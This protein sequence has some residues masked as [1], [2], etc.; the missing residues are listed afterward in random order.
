MPLSTTMDEYCKPNTV[1]NASEKWLKKSKATCLTLIL[2]MKFNAQG[3]QVLWTG[4]TASCQNCCW[5]GQRDKRLVSTICPR[6]WHRSDLIKQGFPQ[7]HL[8]LC[9]KPLF[10]TSPHSLFK[11]TEDEYIPDAESVRQV[12]EQHQQP[13]T[14]SLAQ[15]FQLYTK[16]EQVNSSHA[17][18]N[19]RLFMC[20]LLCAN[21]KCQSLPSL[22]PACSGW[23]L[24]L[25]AL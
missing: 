20:L 15:C 21:F 12:K 22:I 10:Y 7:L 14:C 4:R 9:M 16:E 5:V 24:A 18:T 11:R 2:L 23:R 1:A 19:L 8:C 17:C 6:Q 13:Q 3:L 25:S